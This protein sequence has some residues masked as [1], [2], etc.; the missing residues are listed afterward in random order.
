MPY[1][2]ATIVA[3]FLTIL[4]GVYW[5]A[6]GVDPKRLAADDEIPMEEKYPHFV[7]PVRQ[8]LR[9]MGEVS[10]E[11]AYVLAGDGVRLHGAY[12]SFREGAP[13]VLMFHGY[14]SSATRDGMGIFRICRRTGFNLL[15]VDQRAHRESG[16]RSITFGV[17]ERYDCLEWVRY[18]EKRFGA[19]TEMILVGLSMGAS[20]VLMASELGLSQ[21]VKGIIADC[22]YS[23]PKDILTSVIRMMKLPV[24]PVYFMV[25]LSAMLFGGF[26]P[27]SA[28]ATEALKSCPVPVLLIHG[29]ADSL[30][31]CDMSRKNY[32]ACA[33]EKELFVVPGADHGMS[34]MM[35][36]KT[37]IHKMQSFL[38]NHFTK[39]E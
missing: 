31:P 37:Y 19:S 30:V 9:E 39:Q 33:S 23:T 25:R 2:I 22:G 4:Y 11:D 12:Y 5:F 7:E 10:Y 27:N 14:R 18:V 24:F 13:I 21:Q 34:Y 6:F 8:H 26:D 29:E 3:V 1:V 20:T 38:E 28:S 17:K 36:G 35:D 16:G 32:E 15:I